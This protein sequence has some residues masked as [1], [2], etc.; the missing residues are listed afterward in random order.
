MTNAT[1]PETI[2]TLF[3]QVT[4]GRANGAQLL[5]T[6]GPVISEWPGG[7]RTLT[8]GKDPRADREPAEA[9]AL[10]AAGGLAVRAQ[11]GE[12]GGFSSH[13]TH[14]GLTLAS[15]VSRDVLHS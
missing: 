5:D 4:E 12:A 13:T 11:A 8:F 10:A 9:M 6:Y 15:H 1:A 3:F 14:I 7:S 2:D